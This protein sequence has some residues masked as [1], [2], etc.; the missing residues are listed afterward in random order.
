[1]DDFLAKDL[2]CLLCGEGFTSL[3]VRKS[4]QPV[5]KTDSDFCMYYEREV[6]YFYH[7]YV[8]PHC[9]YAFLESFKKKPPGSMLEKITS[10]PDFF[11]GKRDAATAELAYRRAIECAT[12]Q[13]EGDEVMASLYLQ[14]AWV[15]RLRGEKE[16]E[17]ENLGEALA[18]YI[19]V[20][21]NSD[22]EDASRV[23]Y[24]IGELNRRLGDFKKAVFWFSRVANDSGCS[25]AMRHRARQGWQSLKQ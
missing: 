1:M 10:L 12:L 16:K 11:A 22:L 20:Y 18:Y 19:G 8:C 3:A 7:V 17:K 5:L 9:G 25:Q 21:E 23:M 6:P 24:L 13:R 4:R 2:T 14:L 15:N